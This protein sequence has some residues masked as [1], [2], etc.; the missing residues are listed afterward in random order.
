MSSRISLLASE[1]STR[2]GRRVGC[3]S[4][5]APPSSRRIDPAVAIAR[6]VGDAVETLI[7]LAELLP[8]ALDEGAHV[9][10]EPVLAEACHEILAAHEIVDLPVRDVRIL[11]RD[12]QPH[13]VELRQR[14]IDPLAVIIGPADVRAQLQLA[15]RDG[16]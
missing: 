8:Y 13:D 6:V 14:Q 3:C 4:A 1:R 7:D 11:G 2:L 16:S 5:A 9:D 10:A 12:E 15:A